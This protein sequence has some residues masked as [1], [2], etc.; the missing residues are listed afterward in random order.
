MRSCVIVDVLFVFLTVMAPTA[1][2][3]PRILHTAVPLLYNLLKKIIILSLRLINT[4]LLKTRF[5]GVNILDNFAK[6]FFSFSPQISKSL[7]SCIS[8]LF[9]KVFANEMLCYEISVSL[10]TE[11]YIL[12][13]LHHNT[14]LESY[15]IFLLEKLFEVGMHHGFFGRR[16]FCLVKT[17]EF[18]YQVETNL[19]LAVPE[20]LLNRFLPHS[21]A[22]LDETAS[23]LSNSLEF[24]S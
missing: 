23:H 17:K 8:A 12:V 15:Q 14:T 18:E 11:F 3:D 16:A 1:T 24:I 19:V 22:L 20:D 13:C 6:T 9:A 4:F 2:F 21:R 7:R 10:G 5:P